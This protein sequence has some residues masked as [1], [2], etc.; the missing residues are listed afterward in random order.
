VR[1]GAPEE[2]LQ[3]PQ[4]GR[5]PPYEVW[6][7]R[8]PKDRYYVFLDRANGLGNYQLIFS[9]DV[10]EN[11][12]PNWQE[13]LHKQDAVDDISRFLGIELKSEGIIDRY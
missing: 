6:R 7:F 2:V 4:A 1:N 8:S 9:N 11:G 10:K 3:R 13:L 12:Q 5:S